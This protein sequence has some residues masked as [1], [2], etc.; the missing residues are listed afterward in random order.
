MS[1]A[2]YLAK[3]AQSVTSQGVL[4][5]TAVQGGGGGSTP[6]ITA[7]GYPGNDTAV[8]LAGGNTV[9][10]TGTNFN[11]GVNVI[12]NG[13]PASVVTR[14]SST[15]LTFTTTAQATGSYII[16]VVNTDGST[17][18]A[19]PGLQYSPV[20]SWTTAA[21]SLGAPVKNFS[22]S[23]TLAS[24]GD[25]PITYSVVSGS[26][27][28]G[29][30]L[31]S[32]TGVLSG[33]TPDVSASTTYNF[34][35][36][37]TD[38]QNQD[39]DRAFSITVVPLN[40]TP[41]VQYLVVAGGGAGGSNA[42][43]WSIQGPG[44]AGGF[45]TSVPGATSGGNSSAEALYTISAGVPITVTVGAGGVNGTN[46]GNSQFGTIISLGGGAGAIPASGSNYPSGSTAN[47]GGS[48]G[49]GG[50]G[51][52]ATYLPTTSGAGTAGQGFA[53]GTKI[54]GVGGPGWG[55][56]GGGGAGAVGGDNSSTSSG[57]GGA[58]LA[59]SITGT[60]T[61]YAGGGGAAADA[62]TSTS[63]GGTGG[64]GGGGI[65]ARTNRYAT[66]GD[67]N[68]GGGGGG[69]QQSSGTTSISGSGG[70]GIVVVRYADTYDAAT[71]TTGSPTITV[72][73]GYRIYKFTSSGSI[74]F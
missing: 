28:S 24:T 52:T 53:G 45:R 16:Y 57:N 68:T 41:T 13:T 50:G 7:I 67:T 35:V 74:T 32:S 44:G 40:A 33:T 6:T 71:S 56:A 10:L 12:V 2:K 60:S 63:S 21:G 15:Q 39:S 17:A 5:S 31:N 62:T 59:S 1:I 58:G 51:A 55:G 20:P 36:R 66:D 37:S 9:T 72:A 48:G 23:T 46:G 54:N 19:V 42:K 3:L 29:I 30:T 64:I 38:A 8:G 18:L 65:G 26:L 4:N 49:G 70:S 25:A 14:I 11:V 73:G 22:F 43:G 69:G 61:Y 47:D 34:T 27:P